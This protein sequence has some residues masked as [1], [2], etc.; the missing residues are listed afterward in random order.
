MRE[1][2]K[3]ISNLSNQNSKLKDELNLIYNTIKNCPNN[4]ELGKK[5]RR[6]C[7]FG[8]KEKYHNPNQLEL[9]N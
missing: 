9:F 2:Y 8:V 5:I 3:Q 1:E 4:M 6:E 7:N